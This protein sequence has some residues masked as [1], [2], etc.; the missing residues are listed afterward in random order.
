M[1]RAR[2]V[3]NIDGILTTKG[4]IYA[5]TAASTPARLGAGNNGETLVADSSASV[6][7]RYQANF[8]AG[9]NKVINGDFGIWQ[10]G[11]SISLTTATVVYNADRF[12]VYS[13]F[14]AGSS[15]VSRETFTP[16]AAPVAG[17]EGQYFARY[18][19]GSTATYFEYGQKVENVQT[20]A[21]QTATF[22]FWAKAS[23]NTT[24][25]LSIAQNFGSGGSTQVVTSVGTNAVTTS[26]QRFTATFAVP[27]ISGK[28]IGTSSYLTP[29][30]IGTSI[31]GSQTIDFWGWQLEA[32]NTATAFQTATGTL[33]GE[34]A[35]CM[36]YFYAVPNGNGEVISNAFAY[37]ASE[38]DT[39]LNFP[40]Q[41]RT[42][43]TLGGTGGTNF[44]GYFRNGGEDDFDGF[45]LA[46]ESTAGGAWIYN[47]SQI[48][49]TAGQAGLVRFKN[50]SASLTFSAEL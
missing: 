24:L 37:A 11:T 39:V 14:S 26:W 23:A 27:S 50:A 15:S 48:S 22:S 4:D 32:G 44:F 35:A 9:K 10:R 17:Y 46:G 2:D 8:A 45:T 38:V 18:T 28:T 43:P 47:N 41:M 49:G 30:L 5:A 3:A 33:Q 40:V 6:G 21:G 25:S 34:L 19:A 1:T 29:V 42:T 13:D 20:L 36:R 31:T 16:G 7:I 12:Y